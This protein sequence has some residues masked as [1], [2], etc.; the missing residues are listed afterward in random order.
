VEDFIS[1]LKGLFEEHYI[2]IPEE[3]VQV[4]EELTSKVEELEAA[5]NEQIAR[6][7]NLQSH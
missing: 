5:L 7:S 3:K 4:V 1:G 6:V 2:D